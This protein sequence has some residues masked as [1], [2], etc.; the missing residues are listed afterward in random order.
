MVSGAGL[1]L[2][3]GYVCYDPP[4]TAPKVGPLPA[5]RNAYIRFGSFNNLAKITPHVV[6]VWA[7]VLNRVPDSRL[8]LKYQGLG[9]ESICRRYLGMFKEFGV[10]PARVELTPPSRVCRVSLGV[11]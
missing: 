2:P 5:A 3:D 10:D 8:V 7:K 6:E 1:R 11:R 9:V 4:R